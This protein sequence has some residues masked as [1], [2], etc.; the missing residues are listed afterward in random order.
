[1]AQDPLLKG[2]A[3]RIDLVEV[4]ELRYLTVEGQG[5]PESSA[6]ADAVQALY[7]V[8]YGARFRGKDLGHDE[9]VGPLE[10]LW[11]ADDMTAYAKGQRDVWRWRMMIRSPS[12]LD[13]VTLDALRQVALTKRKGMPGVV[14]ALS[15][16]TLTPLLEGT[17]LQALHVGPYSDEAPLIARMHNEDMPARGLK[18]RGL[19]HEIYLSDPR[20]TA[21]EKLKTIIRQPVEPA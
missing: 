2:K 20:R 14:D 15:R 11:W 13:Q 6:Y 3:G 12:W 4:P 10:G 5:S 17:C 9:K 8:A 1:M 16:L 19:H 21:A 18:P 7:T